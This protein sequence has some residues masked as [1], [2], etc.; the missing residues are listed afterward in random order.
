M[1]QIDY[2]D[3]SPI[4]EQIRDK[5]K[6]LVIKGVLKPDEQ[7]PSVRE[8]AQS[9]TIN[10]NTIQKAYKELEDR[11]YIYSIRGKGSF[12][13]PAER[14]MDEKKLGELSRGLE[15]I[16][17]ELMLFGVDREQILEKVERICRGE[18]GGASK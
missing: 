2:R 3:R 1:I 7:I 12:V 14:R 11:G 4:Y 17:S 6:E 13:A 8:L 9:L 16:V 15:K 10:P 5:M 18:E